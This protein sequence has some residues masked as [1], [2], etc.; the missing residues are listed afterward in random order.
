MVDATTDSTLARLAV[1]RDR[2]RGEMGAVELDGGV[3]ADAAA[4][5]AH[6]AVGLGVP[7]GRYDDLTPLRPQGGNSSMSTRGD[8]APGAL[9]SSVPVSNLEAVIRSQI[10][11]GAKRCYQR[12]LE[13]DPTQSGTLVL[14]VRVAPNG[15]VESVNVDSNTGL[16]QPVAN[17]TMKVAGRAKFDAP[18]TTPKKL[19]ADIPPPIAEAVSQPPLG[20]RST[21]TVPFLFS[22]QEMPQY[23]PRSAEERSGF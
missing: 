1:L 3:A 17:C 11:P 23:A 2:L 22:K 12:G 7:R 8:V 18:G 9:S 10:Q 15:D 20:V 5:P 4:T 21:I 13:A 16:S 14:L 19:A 6:A